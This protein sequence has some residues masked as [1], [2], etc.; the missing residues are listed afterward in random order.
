MQLSNRLK[1]QHLLWRAGFGPAAEN[2]ADLDALSTEHLWELLLKASDKVLQKIEVA[3][4]AVTEL[5]DMHD[6][7]DLQKLSI[8]QKRSLRQQSRE[9][10]KNLN[11]E[12][13][14]EMIY[15]AGQFREKMS[16]F[17]HGHFAC[18]VVNIYYQQELL[19]IVRSNALGKFGD[20]LKAVSKAPGML[21][22]LNNQQNRKQHPNENFAREVMELFTMGRGNYSEGDVKEAARAFT[23]WSF[24]SQDHFVFKD[25]QHDNGDK[26]FL[27]KTGKFTGDDIIDII[28]EQKKTA[29]FI[30]QKIYYYFVNEKIDSKRLT[31]LADRFYKSEYDIKKLMA[32]IF[33]SDWFYDE[34]N[35]GRRIKS[36]VELLVGIRRLLPLALN[37]NSIQ[38]LI[39]RALGQVLFYPPNVA[40]WPGGRS[41]IDSSTLML[42][43]KIPQIITA[44]ERVN[45]TPKTDDDIMMGQ[46]ADVKAVPNNIADH[47]KI[48]AVVDWQKVMKV[49]E[50]VSRANLLPKISETVLQTRTRVSDSL[51]DK[52]INKD[53]RE[54]YIRSAVIYLMSTPEYQLC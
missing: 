41:W 19:D 1:N 28:L 16:L 47:K 21:Q 31:W 51:L 18:R 37:N 52:Y 7:P 4:G 29:L 48:T 3:A 12:W 46:M 5:P 22:F 39:Q 44:G 26:T 10:I 9:H 50:N 45:I 43:L 11:L 20:M 24:N 53:S 49:F 8:E 36:P 33:T 17:W 54:N 14:D 34:E 23:G 6:P 32:D 42:R 30:T 40:G 13:I 27:G 25:N 2:A 35:I 15:S 38:L